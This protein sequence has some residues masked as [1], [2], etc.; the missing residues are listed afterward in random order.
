METLVLMDR[1]KMNIDS[2]SF[3]EIVINEK[4]YSSDVIIFKDY[5]MSNWWRKEGHNLCI[6]DLKEVL[7]KKP[8]ILIVGTGKMGAMSVPRNVVNFL[9][10][11]GIEVFAL[12][13]DEACVKYNELIKS[14]NI[15]A[16]LHLT[17]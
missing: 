13:T 8:E 12:R 17:C 3:G 14:R 10:S 1:G 2:Y 9:M 4:S 6:D 7:D 16:A 11:Q 5:V 15:V